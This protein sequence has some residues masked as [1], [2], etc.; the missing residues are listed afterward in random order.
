M[1]EDRRSFLKKIAGSTLGMA[2]LP[3]SIPTLSLQPP[4]K[5]PLSKKD[6]R[7]WTTRDGTILAIT[8]MEDSH[9]L[10]VLHL[11][12]Q[13]GKELKRRF[14]KVGIKVDPYSQKVENNILAELRKRGLAGQAK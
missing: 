8:D 3:L 6:P 11:L 2:F 1:D 13:R 9:L 5:T 10:S 4:S 12:I 14:Y 7:F